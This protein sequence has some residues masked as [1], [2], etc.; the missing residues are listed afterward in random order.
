MARKEKKVNAV[1][2]G[3]KY[4]AVI[5]DGKVHVYPAKKGAD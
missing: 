4:I 5:E 2:E 1:L 3:G